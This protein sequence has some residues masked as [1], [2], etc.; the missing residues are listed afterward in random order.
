MKRFSQMFVLFLAL[1]L[2]TVQAHATEIG[3]RSAID[4]LHADLTAAPTQTSVTVASRNFFANLR[5]L[6]ASARANGIRVIKATLPYEAQDQVDALVDATLAGT[7]TNDQINA[8]MVDIAR[9]AQVEGAAWDAAPTLI[10]GG[11]ILLILG[12]FILSGAHPHRTQTETT[13]TTPV[14]PF[15]PTKPIV[16]PP[17]PRFPHEP[18]P[19]FP[20]V[21]DPSYPIDPP[22]IDPIVWPIYGCV[23]SGIYENCAAF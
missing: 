3:V 12:I 8:R 17:Y 6:D 2:P 18:F 22:A 10:I 16:D 15:D 21:P 23:G 11:T 4:Q 19:V 20:G 5:S 13:P 14:T 9:G 1:M 7:L